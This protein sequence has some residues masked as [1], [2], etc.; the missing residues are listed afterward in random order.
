MASPWLAHMHDGGI[1]CNNCAKAREWWNNGAHCHTNG[2]QYNSMR[3]LR[4]HTKPTHWEIHH[5]CHV[6]FTY[7][8]KLPT[9]YIHGA[10]QGKNWREWGRAQLFAF[11]HSRAP[12][13]F[14]GGKVPRVGNSL[15]ESHN[16]YLPLLANKPTFTLNSMLYLDKTRNKFEG[17]LISK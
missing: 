17:N 4:T 7:A 10:L 11:G 12:T 6:W 3:I 13:T 5:W 1:A 14:Y 9:F 8:T 2:T 16:A 15:I